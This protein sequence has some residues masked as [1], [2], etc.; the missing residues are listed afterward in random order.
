M[1]DNWVSAVN[2]VFQCKWLSVR[3]ECN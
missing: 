2:N 1:S 3:L